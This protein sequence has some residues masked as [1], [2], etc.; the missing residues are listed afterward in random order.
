MTPNKRQVQCQYKAKN[1]FEVEPS[2]H[3]PPEYL[4][5]TSPLSLNPPTNG[6]FNALTVGAAAGIA[7]YTCAVRRRQLGPHF[8]RGETTGLFSTHLF[9]L[10]Y[11]DYQHFEA[12]WTRYLSLQVS[13]LS[14]VL[15][16]T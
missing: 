6:I 2:L 16:G 8:A 12:L 11:I 7:A 13:S 14:L 3:S 5:I 9:Q 10:F 1:T 15:E 4:P